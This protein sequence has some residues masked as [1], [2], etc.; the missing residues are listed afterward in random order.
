MGE[1]RPLG[2]TFKVE[3]KRP[4]LVH[5]EQS[6]FAGVPEWALRRLAASKGWTFDSDEP[7]HEEDDRLAIACMLSLD[8]SLTKEEVVGRLLNRQEAATWGEGAGVD[9]EEVIR[10][11]MLAADQ[12]QALQQLAKRRATQQSAADVR[13][14]GIR[15]FEHVSKTFARRPPF[16][17]AQ[18]ARK[19]KEKREAKAARD[20]A[21]AVKRCYADCN[22]NIDRAVQVCL[23][24][25]VRAYRDDLNG[26][27]KLSYSARWAHASRSISWTA[28][29]SKR[30]GSEVIR[31]AWKWADTFEGLE[32]SEEAQVILQKLGGSSA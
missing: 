24:G 14:R 30:A 11:T 8:A 23:P 15:T 6:G 31:Q 12:D 22:E 9:L 19:E 17:A 2:I 3:A 27:W 25:H 20:K 13:K 16:K 1:R 4:L 10:D 28:V 32:I 26:R 7:G 5:Q 18:A 21:T 29:G